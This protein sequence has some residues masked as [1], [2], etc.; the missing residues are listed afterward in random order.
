MATHKA[1]P[2]LTD[3]VKLVLLLL[4][5][6]ELANRPHGVRT[7]VKHVEGKAIGKV[8]V[9]SIPGSSSP[10]A[11]PHCRIRPFA[12]LTYPFSVSDAATIPTVFAAAIFLS[13]SLA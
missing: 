9:F 13:R 12:N 7:T 5:T 4:K 6:T 3:H 8:V 10:L 11:S 1:R 2:P